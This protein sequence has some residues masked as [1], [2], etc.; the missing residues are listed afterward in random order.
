MSKMNISLYYFVIMH[1]QM[2]VLFFYKKCVIGDTP[3]SSHKSS[4]K[5]IYYD[6]VY[7][8]ENLKLILFT[9]KL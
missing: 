4:I 9:Q 2:G 5:L 6:E 1:Y 7:F 3:D 8:L